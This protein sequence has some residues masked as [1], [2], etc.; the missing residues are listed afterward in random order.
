[1]LEQS[2]SC[3]SGDRN[4][5]RARQSF[6]VIQKRH[7]TRI[8]FS[9]PSSCS[10]KAG[11]LR[12]G[13]FFDVAVDIR[14]S[15][16]TYGHWMGEELSFENGKQLFIPAGFL[17]GF[18]TLEDDTEIVYK[19]SEFYAPECDGAVRFDDPDIGI[20]WPIDVSDVSIS[21]KDASAPLLREIGQPFE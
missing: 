8:A 18:I 21:P 9:V 11:P 14:K 4:R 13:A 20:E 1:M 5:I 16:P 10:G 6:H 3:R 7:G 15:S 12:K 19:C 2:S 17:H